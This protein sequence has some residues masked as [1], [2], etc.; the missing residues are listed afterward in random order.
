MGGSLFLTQFPAWC[1]S[2]ES[3]VESMSSRQDEEAAGREEHAMGS[4]GRGFLGA[5]GSTCCREREEVGDRAWRV[6]GWV[7]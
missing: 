3:V 1:I 6:G 4:S 2:T 7:A 5:P